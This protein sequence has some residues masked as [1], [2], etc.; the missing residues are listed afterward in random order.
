MGVHSSFYTLIWHKLGVKRITYFAE[1]EVKAQASDTDPFVYFTSSCYLY[2]VR[3]N[4]FECIDE[5]RENAPRD[6]IKY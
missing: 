2:L 4:K 6:K 3:R 1:Y 5:F